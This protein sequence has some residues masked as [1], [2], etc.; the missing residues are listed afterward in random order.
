MV[1]QFLGSFPMA[2][3]NHAFQPTPNRRRRVRH[4]IQTPAYASFAAESEGAVLDLHEIVDISEDGIAIQC[5]SKLSAENPL[6]LRLDLTDCPQQ[7]FTTGQV[8]WTNDSGR[9]G[10]RFS[11]LPANSL[12][13][14]REWLFVNVMA[15]VANGELELGAVGTSAS[16][17]QPNY[18][19]T[20]AALTAVQRQVEAMGADLAGALQLLADRSQSLLRASGSAIALLDSDPNFMICR[21]SSGADAPPAGV[22]LQV[23]SGF[24][25]ECVKRAML[26]RCDDAELDTRVDRESSRALG[27]R[28]IIAA[29]IQAGQKSIGIVESLSGKPN[30]FT[31]DDGRTLQRLADMV[32]EAVNRSTRAEHLPDVAPSAEFNPPQGSV[33]FASAREEE[34]SK[35]Q[36]AAT[37]LTLPRS[38]LVLLTCAAATIAL[39]LGFISAPWIQSSVVPWI[40]LKF[41]ARSQPHLQTVL[42]SSRA[43]NPGLTSAS[44]VEPASIDQLH[45]LADGGDAAAQNALG[46]RYAT[47][48]GVPLDEQEAVHWFT[49]A[50]EQG[51]V[52]A[53]SKLGSIYYS[54]RGVPQDSNR[55]YFWM[56]VA[57][58]GGDEASKTLAPFVRARLTRSQVASIEQDASRWIQQHAATKPS[59][60][61]PKSAL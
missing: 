6:N 24:S 15:G 46:L 50:A 13:V 33:L 27:I 56:V 55:A 28:S 26:L 41:S 49:K 19:D 23:G 14:L 37:S 52:P 2:A 44:A 31:E 4:K 39:A 36:K 22:R 18:T 21:A 43:P 30:A 40:Q 57:R 17:P 51:N 48:D 47:G 12:A 8:I 53:Q 29:P 10:L 32:L 54:G 1:L 5:H 7:I 45:H 20:L 16:A 34:E 11:N 58:I 38:Y 9:A 61:Q 60:A 25:G 59:A 3:I 35:A 42:A